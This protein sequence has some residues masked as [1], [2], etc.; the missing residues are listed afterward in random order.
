[1]STVL[2]SNRLPREVVQSLYLWRLDWMTNWVWFHSRPCFEQRIK[3]KT[4]PWGPFQPEFFCEPMIHCFTGKLSSSMS[5]TY[6]TA[7]LTQKKLH[8][9]ASY[10]L[11]ISRDS[12]NVTLNRI[13]SDKGVLP[14]LYLMIPRA[15]G[16]YRFLFLSQAWKCLQQG[17]HWEGI[18]TVIGS[19]D[20][21]NSWSVSSSN[22]GYAV[23]WVSSILPFF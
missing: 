9:K 2:R 3:L 17:W 5:K 16:E 1:M 18:I 8:E 22:T 4:G 23:E 10:G 21:N 14:W 7:I 15:T 13:C 19:S 11:A 6:L 12:S 20:K